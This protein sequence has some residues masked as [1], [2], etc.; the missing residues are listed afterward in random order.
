MPFSFMGLNSGV[1]RVT[2]FGSSQYGR[3][4]VMVDDVAGEQVPGVLGAIVKGNTLKYNQ[5]IGFPPAYELKPKRQR[6]GPHVR[7]D[8]RW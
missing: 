8:H 2:K 4:L 3:P 5:R 7:C 1:L 6:R